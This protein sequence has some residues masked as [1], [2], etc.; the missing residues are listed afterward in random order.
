MMMPYGALYASPSVGASAD[1]AVA[2]D[3]QL[4]RF[5]KMTLLAMMSMARSSSPSRGKDREGTAVIDGYYCKVMTKTDRDTT[6]T[7]KDLQK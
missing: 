3:P 6:V 4:F 7:V 1:E 5:W 2:T